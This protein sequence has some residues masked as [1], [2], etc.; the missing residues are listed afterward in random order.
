M[1]R[2]VISAAAE[3]YYER[4]AAYQPGDADN[5]WLLLALCEAAA[6]LRR[7]VDEVL[8]H[9]DIG[10][11]LR[12]LHSPSRAPARGLLRLRD[13]AGVDDVGQDEARLRRD[14][15]ER[16]RAR[17][18]TRPALI[19]D[20]LPTLTTGATEQDVRIFEGVGGD[21]LHTIVLT[22]AEQTPDA[23][24]TLRA[25]KRHE[26]LYGLI[27]HTTDDAPTIGQWSRT[28]GNTSASFGAMT[29]GDVT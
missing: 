27:E 8:R 26:V 16:P 12:R 1:A 18:C 20:V 5:G 28:L 2:P 19:A 22:R 24:A 3:R 15:A 9:D 21:A 10:S 29:L 25:V 17:R 14:I 13:L 11:G 4:L 23:A 7:P 6:T